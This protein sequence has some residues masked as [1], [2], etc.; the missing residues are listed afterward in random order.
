[1]NVALY[2]GYGVL[3]ENVQLSDTQGLSGSGAVNVNERIS[4]EVMTDT[5]M[6]IIPRILT[7]S[8]DLMPLNGTS[9]NSTI[10]LNGTQFVTIPDTL[11]SDITTMSI[12][13]WIKPEFNS[14]TPQFT[15]TS[16]E[17]SFNLYVTNI[18]EPPHTV[19]F[20]IFDGV[21]WNDISGNKALRQAGDQRGR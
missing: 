9:V 10:A 8:I 14:G 3:T 13:S 4:F 6:I 15:I 20:S 21:Q 16:K 19:G 18:V 1:M 5:G 2:Y 12:S 11:S 17:N 7:E